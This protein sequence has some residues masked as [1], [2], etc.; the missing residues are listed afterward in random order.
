M[1]LAYNEPNC[2]FG[3]DFTVLNSMSSDDTCTGF[4]E[5][6]PGIA[7]LADNGGLTQTHALLPGSPAR[8]AALDFP[9]LFTDQRQFV[10]P[11]DSDGDGVAKWDIGAFEAEY[12]TFPFKT[13]IPTDTPT[14][15]PVGGQSFVP[16]KMVACH[17]G[18]AFLYAAV[19]MVTPGTNYPLMGISIDSNWYQVEFYPAV[20]CWVRADTG[21]PS[22]DPLLVPVIPIITITV[23][24]TLTSTPVNCQ[25]FGSANACNSAAHL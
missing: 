7:S 1:L 14:P 25:S 20:N 21:K 11:L 17:Q 12:K 18:P 6:D 23:T 16:D 2:D 10:R 4:I 15:V 19:G 8:D 22:G 13:L 3:D 24:P 5:E 9:S